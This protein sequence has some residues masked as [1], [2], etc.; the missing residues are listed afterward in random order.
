MGPVPSPPPSMA[1]AAAAAAAAAAAKSPPAAY[2]ALGSNST[3]GNSSTSSA[4]EEEPEPEP[5]VDRD[6]HWMIAE[7]K[8][9]R[10]MPEQQ[11][12]GSGHNK[13]QAPVSDYEA[14]C[15]QVMPQKGGI[16]PTAMH[17]RAVQVWFDTMKPTLK[18]PGSKRR[19]KL[20]YDNCF[21]VVLSN[22]N[23]RRYSAA[24]RCTRCTTWRR[25]AP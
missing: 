19:S 16:K 5:E 7:C 4:E 21:Q 13:V 9:I 18:A 2:A 3:S 11:V 23:L 20:K 24:R 10:I 12:T 6:P 1:V 8:E 15:S 17:G 25:S 14:P 22:F